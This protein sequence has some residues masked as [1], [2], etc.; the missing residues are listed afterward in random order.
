MNDRAKRNS[1]FT[2]RAFVARNTPCLGA[3]GM[4]WVREGGYACG[5]KTRR[6]VRHEDT[7]LFLSFASHGITYRHVH[8]KGVAK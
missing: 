5:A 3:A 4:R 1:K 7:E 8:E 6:Q 2:L